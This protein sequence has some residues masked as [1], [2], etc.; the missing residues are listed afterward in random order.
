MAYLAGSYMVDDEDDEDDALTPS[1]PALRRGLRY[2]AFASSSTAADVRP[3]PPVDWS[4]SYPPGVMPAM[5]CA[6]LSY[7]RCCCLCMPSWRV[8]RSSASSSCARVIGGELGA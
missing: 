7:P 1:R 4:S 5:A 6:V 2:A 8:M 3:R